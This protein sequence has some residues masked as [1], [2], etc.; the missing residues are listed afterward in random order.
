MTIQGIVLYFLLNSSCK[1]IA[2]LGGEGEGGD[3]E[4]RFHLQNL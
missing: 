4:E 2:H 1:N 3:L